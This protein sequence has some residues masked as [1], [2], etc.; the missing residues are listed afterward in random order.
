MRIFERVSMVFI[1]L[2]ILGCD[3][4]SEHKS[5]P[6]AFAIDGDTVSIN[7]KIH[8][9]SGIDAP[10]LGQGC[11]NGS[12]LDSCGESAAFAL[13]KLIAL[14]SPTC[15]KDA[16][17][18]AFHCS[19]SSV[20]LAEILLEQGH[21]TAMSDAPAQYREREQEARTERLG[22]WRGPLIQPD[23]WRDGKRLEAETQEPIECR[24]FGFETTSGGKAYFTPT[25]PEY[26]VLNES[27]GHG[28]QRFCSDEDA[29]S[30]GYVWMNAKASR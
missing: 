28:A 23:E 18:S 21:V 8:D 9:L 26:T 10:E 5:V 4:Q 14:D 2:A 27:Y 17:S 22:I 7:G 20:N 25:H 15:E 16:G 29:R 6:V 13:A 11:E 3:D 12:R 24:V 1:A 30:K 19:T